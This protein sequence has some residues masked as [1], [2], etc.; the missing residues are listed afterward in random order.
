MRVGSALEYALVVHL[1]AHWLCTRVRF[2]SALEYALVE[3]ALVV[4]SSA[5]RHTELLY[6]TL[7]P[8]ITL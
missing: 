7:S 2:G 4:R 1:S 6:F 5:Y 3:C 8:G